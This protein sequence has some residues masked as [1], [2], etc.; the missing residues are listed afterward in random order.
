MSDFYYAAMRGTKRKTVWTFGETVEA[1]DWNTAAL[2]A[3][4]VAKK[5]GYSNVVV[6]NISKKMG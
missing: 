4:E 6:I 3:I 5:K 1:N 2:N